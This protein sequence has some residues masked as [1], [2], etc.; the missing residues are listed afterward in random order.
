MYVN[1][2][3]SPCLRYSCM[4]VRVGVEHDGAEDRDDDEV[5]EKHVLWVDM[6]LKTAT[7]IS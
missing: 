6:A 2:N 4:H 5:G 1:G 3:T 7:M